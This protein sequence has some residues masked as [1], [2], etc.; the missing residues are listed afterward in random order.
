MFAHLRFVDFDV[1]AQSA[2]GTWT[3]RLL[4]LDADRRGRQRRMIVA[5]AKQLTRD[6][7]D[8]NRTVGALE[9]RLVERPQDA[10]QLAAELE[11]ARN[12][13]DAVAA[14]LSDLGG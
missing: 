2:A 1:Q 6:L 10:L 13:R 3:K 9:Q 4:R 5:A 7:A 11:D 8:S 14:D 12:I